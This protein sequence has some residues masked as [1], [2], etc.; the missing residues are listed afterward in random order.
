MKNKLFLGLVASTMILATSC[1]S[2]PQENIDATNAAVEAAKTAQAD[3][4]MSAE[5]TALN[6]SLAVVMTAIEAENANLCKDFAAMTTKLGVL[7]TEAEALALAAPE[8]KNAVKMEAEASIANVKVAIEELNA[9]IAKAPKKASK[10]LVDQVKGTMEAIATSVSEIEASIAGEVNFVEVIAKLNATQE[11]LAG[12]R[13][14]V[15]TNIL[16]K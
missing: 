1:G 7:K 11:A 5:F 10:E 12:V 4:Y 13:T 6:D 3:V 2:L 16:K 14:E 15:D 9:S 8:K